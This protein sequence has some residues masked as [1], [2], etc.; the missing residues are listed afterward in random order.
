MIVGYQVVILWCCKKLIKNYHFFTKIWKTFLE[1]YTFNEVM[2]GSMVSKVRSLSW[3]LV[4][5]KVLSLAHC[6]SF[7][8]WRRFRLS[9]ALGYHESLSTLMTWCSSRTTKRGVSP[10]WWCG[11]LAWKVKGSMSTWRRVCLAPLLDKLTEVDVD[12]AMLDV[13]ATFWYLRDMLSSGGGWDS[14]IAAR[15]CV[16]W[17]KFRKALPILTTRHLSLGYLA[18]CTRPT[19]AQLCSMVVKRENQRNPNL[20]FFALMIV[21][22]SVGSVISKSIAWTCDLNGITQRGK[23]VDGYITTRANMLLLCEH[24]V[25]ESKDWVLSHI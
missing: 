2:C 24:G 17:G 6:S 1:L 20:A 18:R 10:S 7:W 16:G 4:C 11:R 19:L 12:V 25:K 13:E 21:P 5:I 14:A 9:L 3:K 23:L 8:C 22:W 15:C